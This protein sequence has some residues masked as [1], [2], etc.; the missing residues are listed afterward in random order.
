METFH[1]KNKILIYFKIIEF[2]KCGGYLAKTNLARLAELTGR[3]APTIKG[4][5]V[6]QRKQEREFRRAVEDLIL[7]V[8]PPETEHHNNA[9]AEQT[10]DVEEPMLN[11]QEAEEQTMEVDSPLLSPRTDQILDSILT[12]GNGHLEMLANAA[13]EQQERI[14]SQQI[15][16]TQQQQEHQIG[17]GQN[18]EHN[19]PQNLP[20][21]Y[22][23]QPQT[24]Y[25]HQ[26]MSSQVQTPDYGMFPITFCT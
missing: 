26:Q 18:L 15:P 20:Y 21:G 6:R 17:E 16:T 24:Y 3:P 23:Q 14:T 19:V 1:T 12:T 10:M 13:V 4:W 22:N 7:D 11:N 2:V 9:A 25:Q 8:A 5:F